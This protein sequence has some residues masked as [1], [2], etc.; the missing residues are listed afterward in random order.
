MQ[1]EY[2]ILMTLGAL[3]ILSPLMKSLTE[4]MGVPALVGYIVPGFL[5][6]I[7]NQQWSFVTPAFDN[8][9]SMLAQLGIVALLFHV[10]LK[11]HTR[12]LL[13]K[14]PGASFILARIQ[15]Q[16]MDVIVYSGTS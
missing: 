7:L 13:A 1:S 12:A 10:G 14:L 11:S 5:T 9:F 3:L 8:S 4:R 6:S 2:S 16:F 15:R